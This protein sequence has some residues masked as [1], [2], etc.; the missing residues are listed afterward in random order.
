DAVLAFEL[1]V[2]A[3]ADDQLETAIGH[4]RWAAAVDPSNARRAQSLAVALGRLGYAH[5]AIRVL[6]AHERTDAP[7]LIGRVLADNGH[8]A[9]AVR[10]LWYAAR[11]F[12]TVE[13]WTLLANAAHR[14]GADAV[15]AI[16][17]R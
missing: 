12:R 5:E 3:A 2:A 1:G 8:H 7:R 13:D 6:S 16:A 10:I 4:L 17:G 11:R 9:D 15:A 14:T